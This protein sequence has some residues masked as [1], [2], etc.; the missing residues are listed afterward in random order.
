[1]LVIRSD[2]ISVVSISIIVRD[3]SINKFWATLSRLLKFIYN[4]TLVQV[5]LV[6]HT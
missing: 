3:Y 5:V 2:R 4:G 6:N 1:M